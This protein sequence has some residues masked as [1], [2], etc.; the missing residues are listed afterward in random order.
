[1]NIQKNK[2]IYNGF[3]LAGFLFYSD[4]ISPIS[5]PLLKSSLQPYMI[6]QCKNKDTVWSASCFEQIRYITYRAEVSGFFSQVQSLSNLSFVYKNHDRYK[7]SDFNAMRPVQNRNIQKKMLSFYSSMFQIF[8]A[9]DQKAAL[10]MTDANIPIPVLEDEI[11]TLMSRKNYIYFLYHHKDFK[12]HLHQ[13]FFLSPVVIQ[14]QKNQ[15]PQLLKNLWKFEQKIKTTRNIKFTYS[16]INCIQYLENLMPGEEHFKLLTGHEISAKRERWSQLKKI[17]PP[18]C[19]NTETPA[20]FRMFVYLNHFPEDQ[21]SVSQMIS[22]W[23]DIAAQTGLT[24]FFLK[25]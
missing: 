22:H 17:T 10:I 24:A 3:L 4:I 9:K 19:E 13:L 1:M 23:Q 12:I 14:I 2:L 25:E 5:E 21:K 18:Y 11:K 8:I 20:N 16:I 6:I 15:S 7:I